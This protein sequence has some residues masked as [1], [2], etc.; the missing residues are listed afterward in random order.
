MRRRRAAWIP[1][2]RIQQIDLEHRRDVCIR[3]PFL[4]T[5]LRD[6]AGELGAFGKEVGE[7]GGGRPHHRPKTDETDD[8][9]ESG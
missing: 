7:R 4:A 3:Q 2:D 9:T 6:Q 1:Y 5:K 8:P